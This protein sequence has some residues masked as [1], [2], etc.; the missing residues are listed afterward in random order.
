MNKTIYTNNNNTYSATIIPLHTPK[1]KGVIITMD[2][3][4]IM[5]MQSKYLLALDFH[6]FVS[7]FFFFF[8]NFTIVFICVY[9]MSSSSS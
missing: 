2:I 3:H 7:L 1:T 9:R 4:T 8:R 6:R 5:T